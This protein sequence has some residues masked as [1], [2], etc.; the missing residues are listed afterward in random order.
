MQYNQ[1]DRLKL[2]MEALHT[3]RQCIILIKLIR[4]YMAGSWLWAFAAPFFLLFEIFT[5]LM[6]P[7]MMADI[8]DV[9]VAGGDVPF[10]MST[11]IR[12]ALFAAVGSIAGFGCVAA[13]SVASVK[14][15][16]RLRRSF[17]NHIQTFSFEDLDTFT[18]SSL[19]TRITNDIVQIQQIVMMAL[20]MLIRAPFMSIGGIIMAYRL[21]PSLSLVLLVAVPILLVAT[22]LLVSRGMP[23]FMTMQTKMDRINEVVRE[24]LLGVKV[25]KSYVSEDKEIE[26]FGV[27]NRDMMKWSIKAMNNMVMLFPL[28]NLVMNI[29]IVAVLWA[30][31]TMAVYGRLETG[32]IMAFINYLTQI[33]MSLS[34]VVM[35]GMMYSRAK[36]AAQR[37]NEVLDTEALIRD[38]DLTEE[39]RAAASAGGSDIEFRD[40]SFRYHNSGEWVLKHINLSIREGETVGIIGS[41]GSGKSTLVSLIPRLFDA[42][43]GSVS[44][45]GLD[46]RAYPMAALRQKIGMVLQDNIL[47]SGSVEDNL[48][49]GRETATEEEMQTAA[50]DAQAIDFIHE[51]ENG[52]KAWVEQRGRNFSGGQKQRLSIARTLLRKPDILILDDAASA[53][54]MVTEAKIR[55]SIS[56]RMGSCTMIIIAQ[57]IAAVKDANTILVMHEGEIEAQGAHEELIR[58]SETYRHIVAAQMGEEAI[59]HAG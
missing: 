4:K 59:A 24:N 52:F 2:A 31:G 56:R 49:F 16:G 30:G 28:I 36:V 54:D 5:D 32:K 25:I 47:F 51:K 40:V 33:L 55:E 43:E 48:R 26:R 23:L 9:G 53:V 21:S 12:M 7:S 27:A 8:I 34:M 38:G 57:R 39:T 13:S 1:S 17:F 37:I 18:T 42:T 35:M 58:S 11:G 41:T 10:I 14:F 46:V 3:E 6:Q 19:I 50:E 45:G 22:F 29:S 20:R 15:A 44:V